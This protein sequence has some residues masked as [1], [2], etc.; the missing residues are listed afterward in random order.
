MVIQEPDLKIK[1]RSGWT[2][3]SADALLRHP[4]DDATVCSI[5]G[6][7]GD[8]AKETEEPVSVDTLVFF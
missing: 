1:H 4:V 7:A 8:P 3:A 2:N 5:T 6:E